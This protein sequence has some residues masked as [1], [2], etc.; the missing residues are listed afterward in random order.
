MSKQVKYLFYFIISCVIVLGS[1]LLLKDLPNQIPDIKRL[2]VSILALLI[3]WLLFYIFS[4]KNVVNI[5]ILIILVFG[6]AACLIKPVQI[7]LD[8]D[9]HLKRTL[10]LT[11]S[12]VVKKEEYKLAEYDKIFEFD[13]FRN[14]DVFFSNHSF[15][16][17]THDVPFEFKRMYYISKVPEG[18]RRG[19]HA[20][21]K[22]KGAIALPNIIHTLFTLPTMYMCSSQP[23]SSPKRAPTIVRMPLSR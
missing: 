22:L 14:R 18:T 11:T 20:H 12:G 9:A 1:Q 8:E 10:E 7:G 13:F 15:F 2:L 5:G 6:I 4:K 16:E 21:K 3:F 17:A 19:F 23:T